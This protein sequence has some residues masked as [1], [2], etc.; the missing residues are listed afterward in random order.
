MKPSSEVLMH[1]EVYQQRPDIEGVVHAHPMFATMWAV[2]GQ[3]LDAR[4]LPETVVSMVHIPLANYA[5]PSTPG[6]P[7]SIRPF[8]ADYQACLLEHHGALTW[9]SDVTAAYLLMERLEFTAEILW[10]LNQGGVSRVLPDEEIEH[11]LTLFT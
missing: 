1:L 2:A 5:T 7:E 3:A 11:L 6:V 10:R 4:M 8:V 9:A